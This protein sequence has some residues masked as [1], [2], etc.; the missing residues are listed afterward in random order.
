MPRIVDHQGRRKDSG[1]LSA[2]LSSLFFSQPLDI[3]QRRP[4]II[5]HQGLFSSLCN[6][7]SLSSVVSYL[8]FQELILLSFYWGFVFVSMPRID[9]IFNRQREEFWLQFPIL[10]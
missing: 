10:F 5:W 6:K 9:F 4:D 1:L 2:L 7:I 3:Y 8:L